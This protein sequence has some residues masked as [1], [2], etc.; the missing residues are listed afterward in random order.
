[1]IRGRIRAGQSA[2]DAAA[3]ARATLGA[4]SFPS[5]DS[6]SRGLPSLNYDHAGREPSPLRP[7]MLEPMSPEAI[8]LCLV[9]G[10]IVVAPA[11]ATRRAEAG[12]HSGSI[13]APGAEPPI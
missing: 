13:V 9:G 8:D 11:G 6:K 7:A 12:I 2:A 3:A 4:A 5:R 10:D 1:M